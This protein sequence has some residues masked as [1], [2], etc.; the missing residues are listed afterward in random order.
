MKHDAIRDREKLKLDFAR[1]N[2][3]GPVG[4]SAFISTGIL[5]TLSELNLDGC[6]IGNLGIDTISRCPRYLSTT[7]GYSSNHV[8]LQKLSIRSN[9]ITPTGALNF[10]NALI[11][12]EGSVRDLDLKQ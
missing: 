8:L 12:V 7:T 5:C 6:N 10:A 1:N 2:D 4:C 11:T 9:N 3:I